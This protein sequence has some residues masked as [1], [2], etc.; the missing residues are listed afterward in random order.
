LTQDEKR[1]Q[2]RRRE[3]SEHR[4]VARHESEGD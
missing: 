4:G 2:N 3:W 1:R